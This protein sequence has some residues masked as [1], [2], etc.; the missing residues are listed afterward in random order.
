MQNENLKDLRKE[1]LININTEFDLD[2]IIAALDKCD[3]SSQRE[4]LKLIFEVNNMIYSYWRFM[5]RSKDRLQKLDNKVEDLYEQ[6]GSQ[7]STQK[8]ID[9]AKEQYLEAELTYLEY[10]SEFEEMSE[11][12]KAFR[13]DMS[14]NASEYAMGFLPSV[15]SA[16]TPTLQQ[17]ARELTIEQ[18]EAEAK[19]WK[20]RK[21]Y[22]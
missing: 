22:A 8:D 1:N 15:W 16:P 21:K 13:L 5:I 14:E 10:K 11:I 18:A 4:H 9:Q 19:A 12:Y 6:F 7:K 20:E 3:P 2:K 17:T